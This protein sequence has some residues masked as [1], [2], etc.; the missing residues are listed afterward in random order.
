MEDLLGGT[1]VT[2]GG[3]DMP[4]AEALTNIKYVGFYF[5]AHWAPCC[6]RFTETLKEDYELINGQNKQFEVVFV[7]KDGNQ[8]AFDRNFAEMPWKAVKYD[9]EARK[10]SLEQKYGIM[11]IPMLII[12]KAEDGSQ[13]SD[14]G[15]RDLQSHRGDVIE[16][17]DKC[18]QAGEAGGDG[19]A[20]Q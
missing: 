1:V 16:H 10:K 15:I 20:A 7:S 6:R 19:A 17:L 8:A 2:Q 12:V 14:N 3:G 11:E 18:G 5:G 13:T 4:L 9:D